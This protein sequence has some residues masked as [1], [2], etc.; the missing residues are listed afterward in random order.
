MGE[1]EAQ[2]VR[3]TLSEGGGG[4]RGTE[5]M[6]TARDREGGEEIEGGGSGEGTR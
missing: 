2:K 3:G 1:E 4:E 6:G 5:G